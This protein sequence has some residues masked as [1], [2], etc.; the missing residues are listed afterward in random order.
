VYVLTRNELR[1][2]TLAFRSQFRESECFVFQNLYG[3]ITC[4]EV[5]NKSV[6]EFILILKSSGNS[7]LFV[8]ITAIITAVSL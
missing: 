4:F 6:H 1:F 8:I 2:V 5:V 7:L 3:T